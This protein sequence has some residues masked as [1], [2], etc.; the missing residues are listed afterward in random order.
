MG[1]EAL[2]ESSDGG[3]DPLL[4]DD[5]DESDDDEDDDELVVESLEL[6]E[7][8]GG[9]SVARE[10]CASPPNP[11]LL[12]DGGLLSAFRDSLSGS[13]VDCT[14]EVLAGRACITSGARAASVSG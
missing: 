8:L 10:R 6:E 11:L 7:N 12:S 5:E 1:E 9:R 14:V 4:E 3:G 2:D 13:E